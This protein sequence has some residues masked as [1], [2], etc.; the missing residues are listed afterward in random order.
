M[1]NQNAYWIWLQET[2]G[3]G[4][5]KISNIL[6]N[7]TFAEDFYRASL[8]EKLMCG[9]F[10]QKDINK[11][12]NT[13]LDNARKTLNRCKECEIDIITIGDV[14]YPKRLMEIADEIEEVPT[15]CWC[16]RRAHYNTRI[17]DGRV[18]RTGE[19]IMLGGNETYVSLCRKHY[20]EGRISK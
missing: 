17:K 8:E 3:C 10:S 12:K 6:S 18:V 20:K 9:C 7:F 16:G 13:S 11:L 2:I 15:V 19:Q 1:N 5:R 4:S 14:A